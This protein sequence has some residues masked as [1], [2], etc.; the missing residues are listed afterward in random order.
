MIKLIVLLTVPE[1]GILGH[2]VLAVAKVVLV[3][4]M[5]GLWIYIWKFVS[6]RYFSWAMK[7]RGLQL[8]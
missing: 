2:L 4:L 3:L 5:A 8:R 1:S 6:D 7:K